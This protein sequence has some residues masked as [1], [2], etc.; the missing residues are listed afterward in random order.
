MANKLLKE[1]KDMGNPDPNFEFKGISMGNPWT[2]PVIQ[3]PAYLQFALY[4]DIISL[5][6]YFKLEPAF[7]ACGELMKYQVNPAKDACRSL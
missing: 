3:Y 4:N 6:D 2:N 5:S 7:T 1:L